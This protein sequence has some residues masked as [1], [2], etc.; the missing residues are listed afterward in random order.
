MDGVISRIR[1]RICALWYGRHLWIRGT[2]LVRWQQ[3]ERL[4][5][6]RICSK[7]RKMQRYEDW[8]GPGWDKWHDYKF[9]PKDMR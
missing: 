3:R 2:L 6:V 8:V 1:Q 7:C 9:D 5:Q 4:F